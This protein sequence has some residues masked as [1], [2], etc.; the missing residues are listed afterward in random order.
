M[1]DYKQEMIKVLADN[2][3]TAEE[4]RLKKVYETLSENGDIELEEL[5][6]DM[7]EN[8]KE[9]NT[10]IKGITSNIN[11]IDQERYNE[12][13]AA[14]EEYKTVMKDNSDYRVALS[15]KRDDGKEWDEEV[16]GRQ[17]EHNGEIITVTEGIHEFCARIM[18]EYNELPKVDP[19]TGEPL[20]PSFTDTPAF[21]SIPVNS[22]M[23]TMVANYYDHYKLLETGDGPKKVEQLRNATRIR[24]QKLKQAEATYKEKYEAIEYIGEYD[25]AKKILKDKEKDLKDLRAYSENLGADRIVDK[26]T[27]T[28]DGKKAGL[29]LLT[30]ARAEYRN[31]YNLWQRMWANILGPSLYGPAKDVEKINAYKAALKETGVEDKEIDKAIPE[32]SDKFYYNEI[33]GKFISNQEMMLSSEAVYEES[34]VTIIDEPEKKTGEKKRVSETNKDFAKEFSNKNV[35]ISDKKSKNEPTVVNNKTLKQ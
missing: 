11:Q 5:I 26:E 25:E 16:K 13:V 33:S 20:S 17:Y 21:Q 22:H 28:E 12:E 3:F 15:H 31:K 19:K 23:Y 34:N 8:V 10:F 35:G 6:N 2:S 32:N 30:A 18:K 27:L 9:L 4:I 1:P 24:D 7:A 29:D 14:K